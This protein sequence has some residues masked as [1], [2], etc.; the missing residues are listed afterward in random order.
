MNISGQIVSEIVAQLCLEN[1]IQ[2]QFAPK[3]SFSVISEYPD[4]SHDFKN[5]IFMTSPLQYSILSNQKG[6]F[7]HN[8]ILTGL[9]RGWQNA[10]HR[11]SV[12]WQQYRRTSCPFF[13]AR[14]TTASGGHSSTTSEKLSNFLKVSCSE[15]CF[16]VLIRQVFDLLMNGSDLIKKVQE[17]TTLFRSRM[18]AAG[19]DIIVSIII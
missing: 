19:F 15:Y 5:L 7:T 11:F 9:I 12:R 4:K 3:C 6:A 14:F 8:L 18:T 13:V 16:S 10:K 17:N 2:R 1:S